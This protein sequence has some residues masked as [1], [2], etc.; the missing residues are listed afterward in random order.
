MR[1]EMAGNGLGEEFLRP[2]GGEVAV[3]TAVG[4]P[5]GNFDRSGFIGTI[6]VSNE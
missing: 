4:R 1:D 5:R 2:A 6:R 3:E